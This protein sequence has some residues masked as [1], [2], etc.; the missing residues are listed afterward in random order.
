MSVKIY[1]RDNTS[2]KVHEYG[3]NPHDALILQEDG[4]LHY[5]NLQNCTG[6]M[7]P[8]EGYSFCTVS[9]KPPE[10]TDGERLVDIGGER[11]GINCDK[12]RWRNR[13]QKC[14]C[15]RRNPNLKDCYQLDIKKA[16]RQ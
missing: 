15:C 14:S 2:G 13:H 6:T 3:T 8:E 5:E 4:S 16:V 11:T 1:I 10:D 9:G 12:C 7:Y